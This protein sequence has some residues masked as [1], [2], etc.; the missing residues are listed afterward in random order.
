MTRAI[1]LALTLLS[2]TSASAERNRLECEVLRNYQRNLESAYDALEDAASFTLKAAAVQT[3]MEEYVLALD[4]EIRALRQAIDGRD[5]YF[6]AMVA[7]RC[8][9]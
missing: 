9:D 2:A 3:E 4:P 5:S 6:N 1:I 8:R 7:D